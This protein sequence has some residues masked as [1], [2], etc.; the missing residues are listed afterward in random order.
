[1]FRFVV[2]KRKNMA[3]YKVKQFGDAYGIKES[4]VKSYVH[5]KQLQKDSD[6]FIDTEIDTNKLFIME[7]QLKINNGIVKKSDESTSKIKTVAPEKPTGLTASQKAYA[8]VDFRT[9]EAQAQVKER[10]SELKRIQLEKLAGNLLP[11]DLVEKCL[12]INIQAIIKGFKTEREN[13]AR[14]MVERFGGTRKD[15]VEINAELDKILDVAIK[16]AKKDAE[17]ELDNAVSDYQEVRSRGERK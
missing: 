6:G 14:V 2:A 8:D 11:L 3:K 5:R 10:E 17:F 1:M 7:M 15:L 9:R 12:V 13:M 16:K 4:T